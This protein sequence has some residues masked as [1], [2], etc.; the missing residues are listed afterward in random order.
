MLVLVNGPQAPISSHTVPSFLFVSL[1]LESFV[2]LVN[3]VNSTLKMI[4]L[5]FLEEFL[6][7][8]GLGLGENLVNFLLRLVNFCL[9]DLKNPKNS[10]VRRWN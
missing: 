4:P 10:T 8:N 3:H 7:D 1:L 9:F 5:M 2:P 6:L